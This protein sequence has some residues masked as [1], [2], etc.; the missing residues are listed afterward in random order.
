MERL[1]SSLNAPTYYSW[2]RD[3]VEFFDERG[4]HENL[5]Q[6]LHKTP[7]IVTLSLDSN[8]AADAVHLRD[9]Y[10]DEYNGSLEEFVVD[11]GPSVFEFLI[12]LAMRMNYIYSRTNENVTVRMFWEILDNIGIGGFDDAHYISLGGDERVKEAIDMVMHRQYDED[13]IGGLFPLEDP[14]ENQ[15]NVEIW[16]QM[17]HYLIEKMRREG[18]L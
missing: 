5:F 10:Q 14:Q 12:A 15:R 13:G 16:Y 8:R 7:Y 18:R 2:L 9:M 6:F 11:T 3:K 4:Q 1:Y 17:N